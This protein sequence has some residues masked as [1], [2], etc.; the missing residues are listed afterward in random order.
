MVLEAA[1]ASAG[2]AATDYAACCCCIADSRVLGRGATHYKPALNWSVPVLSPASNSSSPILTPL[3]AGLRE[4]AGWSGSTWLRGA[5]FAKHHMNHVAMVAKCMPFPIMTSNNAQSK[6]LESFAKSYLEC[7]VLC[8][9]MFFGTC[10]GVAFIRLAG[11]ASTSNIFRTPSPP[12]AGHPCAYKS[13]RAVKGRSALWEYLKELVV[14]VVSHGLMTKRCVGFWLRSE[15]LHPLS[16]VAICCW[17]KSLY[18]W[19][20]WRWDATKTSSKGQR[21]VELAVGLE[22]PG[23]HEVVLHL[24]DVRRGVPKEDVALRDNGATGKLFKG[25]LDVGGICWPD[26]RPGRGAPRECH[27]AAPEQRPPEVLAEMRCV[28]A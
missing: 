3:E 27:H 12:S 10:M 21:R 24:E 5:M 2:N 23:S 1:L 6:S 20:C 14:R 22:L 19:K 11:M 17:R 26:P 4:T 28:Q 8:I 18:C 7:E 9:L 16:P 13:S 25:A 15:M